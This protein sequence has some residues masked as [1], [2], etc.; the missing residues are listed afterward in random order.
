MRFIHM[1]FII[2]WYSN[3]DTFV[4]RFSTRN[5]VLQNIGQVNFALQ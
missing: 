4:F 1:V 3:S 2:Y 5:I